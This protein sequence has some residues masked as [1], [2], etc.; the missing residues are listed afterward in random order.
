MTVSVKVPDKLYQK[1]L[2]IANVQRVSVNEVLASAFAEQLSA[3]ERLEQRAAR[4]SRE[5]IPCC[6][7]QSSRRRTR[8][9]RSALNTESDLPA[10]RVNL[11]TFSNLQCT[12]PPS[13]AT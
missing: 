5:K 11:S 2:D 6:N 8:R 3:W 4:G 7:G 13:L 10:R 12:V 9:L 1:A